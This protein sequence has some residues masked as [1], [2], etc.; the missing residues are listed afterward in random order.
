MEAY[1]KDHRSAIDFIK[2]CGSHLCLS[3]SPVATSCV[4]YHRIVRKQL[5]SKAQ[6]AS[7]EKFVSGFLFPYAFF[8]CQIFVITLLFVTRSDWL[9]NI[10]ANFL[11]IQMRDIE[12]TQT[13]IINERTSMRSEG[14]W[15]LGKIF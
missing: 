8:F 2:S 12:Q 5:E 11:K 3:A 6:E 9:Y 14:H 10:L 7:I 4:L 15:D 1:L 13:Q